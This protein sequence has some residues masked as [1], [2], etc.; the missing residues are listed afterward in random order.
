[1]DRRKFLMTAGAMAACCGMPGVSLAARGGALPPPATPG[2]KTLEE[3]LKNRQSRRQFDARPLPEA[4]LSGLLWAANGVNRPEIGKHTA[5]TA[6]NRQEIAVYVAKADG[7]FLYEPKDHALARV[8]D[9]DLRAATGK[10]AFAATAPVDLVYV[11]DMD[12]VAGSTPEEKLFYAGTD[13]G[14]VSQ[15]VYLYCAAMDLATVVRASIDTAALATAMGLPAT[16]RI[17]L[18]QTVGYP[19]A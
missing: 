3:A 15:N 18:A 10:Q 4:V 13:T 5:P 16:R 14:F 19:K 17:T 9:A 1:M 6:M 11:A 12:K 8:K 2:A 7:L